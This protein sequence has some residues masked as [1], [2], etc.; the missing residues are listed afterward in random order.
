MTHRKPNKNAGIRGRSGKGASRALNEEAEE[1]AALVARCDG[2]RAAQAAERVA[3]TWDNALGTSPKQGFGDIEAATGEAQI[4]PTIDTQKTTPEK[5]DSAARH[6]KRQ[7]ES[8]T[9]IRR[10]WSTLSETRIPDLLGFVLG[11]LAY[12]AAA[13]APRG[14]IVDLCMPPERAEEVLYNMLGRY[15][16]WVQRHG[17]RRARMIFTT[18]SIGAVISFWSDW[19][20]KRVRAVKFRQPS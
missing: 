12:E 15:E 18:Q 19:A 1:I 2:A 7:I 14:I 10:G 20:I 4:E 5:A 8:R 6:A 9:R 3:K 13:R 16:H 11:A 17:D